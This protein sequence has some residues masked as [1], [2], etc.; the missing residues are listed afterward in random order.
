VAGRIPLHRYWNP[1]IGD[2]FYPTNWGE[3]GTGQYGWGYEG[4]QGYVFPQQGAGRIPLYRYWNGSAGDHF[5][6]TNWGELGWGN[7]GWVFEGIQCYV[8]AQVQPPVAEGPGAGAQAAPSITNGGGIPASF[9]GGSQAPG[10]IGTLTNG[11]TAVSSFRAVAMPGTPGLAATP[12]SFTS[13]QS[14]IAS[15]MGP[16]S[17][18]TVTPASLRVKEGS[19][20][21]SVSIT[22]EL[23]PEGRQR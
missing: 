11:S 20:A 15:G 1:S 18:A 17:F 10:M 2:H 3:L 6:T 16:S 9:T 5:Y 8:A 19:R 4:I 23:N 21:G 12:T 13:S 7:Y 14:E 22:V